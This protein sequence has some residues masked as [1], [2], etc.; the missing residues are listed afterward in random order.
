MEAFV[1]NLVP[2]PIPYTYNGTLILASGDGYWNATAMCRA[3]GKLWSNYWQNQSTQEFVEELARSLGIP[4][5][6]LVRTVMTGPNDT[7]GTWVHRRLAMHLAQWCS[8]RFAVLVAGWIEELLTQGRVELRPAPAPTLQPYTRRVMLL[9]EVRQG[10]PRGHWSV[11][12]EAADLLIWAEQIFL[13]AGLEMQ[14]YDLLDGS[15]SKRWAQ[16]REGQEWTGVRVGYP[17]PFPDVRGTREAWAYPMQELACFRQS[18]RN[19]SARGVSEK[20]RDSPSVKMP[21]LANARSSRYRA[22]GFVEVAPASSPT[23]FGPSLRWSAIAN[24]AAA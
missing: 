13:P 18:L 20:Q 6:R 12:T 24:F 19:G 3:N 1:S 4:R 14:Q 21:T 22:S 11:F 17:H 9:P 15:V 23:V 7:R 10:V 16:F 8:P 2:S 5:D